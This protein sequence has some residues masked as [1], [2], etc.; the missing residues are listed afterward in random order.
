MCF[1]VVFFQIKKKKKKVICPKRR[2]GGRQWAEVEEALVPTA[3][4]VHMTFAANGRLDP[5][6]I[7]ML[8]IHITQN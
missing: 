6:P 5:V 8:G 2:L 7:G 1:S 3:L 4:S